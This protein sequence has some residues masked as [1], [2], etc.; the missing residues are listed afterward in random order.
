MENK[1]IATIDFT[2]LDALKTFIGIIKEASGS[3]SI[4]GEKPENSS[5]LDNP[6]IVDNEQTETIFCSEIKIYA[7]STIDLERAKEVLNC[8]NSE[9]DK[10]TAACELL[11]SLTN[12]KGYTSISMK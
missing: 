2:S 11:E 8:E 3:V 5:M 10:R 12:F 9:K 6:I 4:S 7:S 1:Y